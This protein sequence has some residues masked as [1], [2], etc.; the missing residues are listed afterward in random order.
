MISMNNSQ[1]EQIENDRQQY[2][3]VIT[4]LMDE[5]TSLRELCNTQKKILDI[6]YT[7]RKDS[8]D[9]ESILNKFRDDS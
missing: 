5:I 9:V 1:V 7:E 2:E 8:I 4:S 3:R 6:F